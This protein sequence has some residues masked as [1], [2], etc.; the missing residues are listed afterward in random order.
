M[1]TASAEPLAAQ[2]DRLSEEATYFMLVLRDGTKVDFIVRRPPQ[3]EPPWVVTRE[4]LAAIDAHFWDWILWS[5]SKR[6]RVNDA[7]VD[8]MLARVMYDHLLAPMGASS[9]P[10]TILAAVELYRSL[11]AER[12]RSLDVNVDHLLGAT[13]LR[14]LSGTGVI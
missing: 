2:W 5:W 9:P 6:L 4:T 3:V 8:V 14:R 10:P 7:L 13:V 12:E 1:L 11:C